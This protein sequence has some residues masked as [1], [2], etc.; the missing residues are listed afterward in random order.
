MNDLHFLTLNELLQIHTY[1]IEHFG[2]DGGVRDA[3][4][5]ESA[6][7]T[8]RQMFGGNYLHSDLASMAA[9]YLFSLVSNHPF[10]DGNKRTGVH[11]AIVF[12]ELNGVEVDL[13]VDE[14]EKLTLRIADREHPAG[15]AT[16]ENVIEFFKHLI[17]T[18]P[19]EIHHEGG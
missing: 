16:K 15:R 8:P 11:A 3:T 13:P 10:N 17:A 5:I 18:P 6:I 12:L 4:L 9:A 7:A 19:S 14:A 1:Q 2:G